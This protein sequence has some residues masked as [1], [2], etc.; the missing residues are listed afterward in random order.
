M[1]T[2]KLLPTTTGSL[3][4]YHFFC[5]WVKWCSVSLALILAGYLVQRSSGSCSRNNLGRKG[6]ASTGGVYMPQAHPHLWFSV[7]QSSAIPL[8]DSPPFVA[9]H[10]LLDISR[11]SFSLSYRHTRNCFSSMNIV[12]TSAFRPGW[13]DFLVKEETTQVPTAWCR[14]ASLVITFASTVVAASDSSSLGAWL[15]SYVSSVSL[16]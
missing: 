5:R 4:P 6:A 8:L 10:L 14:F 2:G 13:S 11:M 15:T 9:R 1:D 16:L 12:G 7:N 3:T